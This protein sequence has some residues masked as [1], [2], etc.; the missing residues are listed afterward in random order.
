[1]S[2]RV[3]LVAGVGSLRAA[4]TVLCGL[5]ASAPDHIVEIRL[6]DAD[7]ERLDLMDRFLRRALD[8]SKLGHT[9]VST[10]TAVDAFDSVDGVIVTL[11]HNGARR[12]LNPAPEPEQEPEPASETPREEDHHEAATVLEFGY[13]DRNRPTPR[14]MLSARL[15]AILH[16]PADAISRERAIGQALDRLELLVPTQ[17]HVLSLVRGVPLTWGRGEHLDWPIDLTAEERKSRP[18]E[19]LR[20]VQ[21]VEDIRPFMQAAAST[22]VTRWLKAGPL[23]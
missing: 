19:L 20:C 8:E 6:W 18:H 22:P 16:N 10:T 3:V 17:A 23:A 1:M 11:T 21:N 14:H 4:P 12:F 15:R 7:D 2:S 5:A 13:G 9:V